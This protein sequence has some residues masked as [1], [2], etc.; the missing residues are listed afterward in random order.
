MVSARAA[1]AAAF[2][3]GLLLPL[4]FAPLDLFPLAIFSPALLFYLWRDGSPARAAWRGWLFGLGMFGVGISWVFVSMHN[5]GNMPVPLAAFATF[6][7]VALLSLYLALLGFVQA[8]W[9]ERRHVAHAALVLPALWVLFEWWRG[10]FLSG[11]PWLNLGY[12]QIDTPLAGYAPLAGVYGVGVVTALSAGLLVAWR[13]HP[14]RAPLLLGGVIALWLGGLALT[15]IEWATP[16]GAPLR[17]TMVQANVALRDKWDPRQRPRILERY[18]QLSISAPASELIVWPEAAIPAALHQVDPVYLDALRE[19][20]RTRNTDV[21]FGVIESSDDRRHYYNSA[22][23]VGRESGVYRKQH[24][25]PLG[26]YTPLEPL[27]RWLMNSFD[28]PMSDFSPAPGP[29]S[30]LP[31]AGRLAGLSVCYE[32]AFG[33]EVIRSLPQAS[34]LVNVSEDAWFG[35]SL[36][37]H[38]RLQMARMRAREAARPMLR[39]ANTGP[40]AAIDHRGNVLARSAQFRPQL[41]YAEVQPM[42]GA[43]AYVLTG[44]WPVVGVLA[45]ALL[46]VRYRIRRAR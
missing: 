25:V 11:F 1:D 33:E 35:D 6:L 42:R 20:A 32:D 44:N 4:A 2:V 21:L 39:A 38:Q 7:L 34:V 22:V 9:F 18:Q 45:L 36:A 30:P 16:D 5:F 10:W 19:F 14:A 37:P 28:I 43:T 8:R 24:L 26:E 12:S 23:V 46:L 3:A 27:L 40:S 41:L 13:A 17:A 29:Q 15:Y 31:L